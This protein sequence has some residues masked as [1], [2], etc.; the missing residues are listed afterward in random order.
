[1]WRLPEMRRARAPRA[2]LLATL[3]LLAP[4]AAARAA[5]SPS[6]ADA[7]RLRA[8]VTERYQVLP[9]REGVLLVPRQ[10]V[11]G[12]RSI[13][14]ADGEVAIN[15]ETVSPGIL[16]SWLGDE[17]EP[18]LA[19]AEVDPDELG[20]VLGLEPGEEAPAA[21]GGEEPAAT[22]PGEVPAPPATPAP[23]GVPPVPETGAVAPVPPPPPEPDRVHI[24]ERFS[25]GSGVT[26]DADEVASEVVCIGGPVRILGKVD[27]DVVAIGGSVVVEGEVGGDVVGVGGRVFLGAES[28]VRRDVVAVGSGVERESGARV[29]GQV[30]QTTGPWVWPGHVRWHPRGWS[31][32][33]SPVR[34]WYLDNLFFNLVGIVL[35]AILVALVLL[36]ARRTVEAA[37]DR[38]RRDFWT[39]ALTG[40]LTEVLLLPVLFV[41]ALVLVL[42]IVGCLALPLIPVALLVVLVFALVGYAGVAVHLGRLVGERFGWRL[43]RLYGP[44][45]IGLLLIEVWTLIGHVLQVGS[46]LAWVFA[47]MFV[48]I[49]ILVRYVAW[50]TGLGAVVLNFFGSRRR[51][52]GAV[53]P[54]PPPLPPAPTPTPGEPAGGSWSAA[55]EPGAGAAVSEPPADEPVAESGPP[56]DLPRDPLEPGPAVTPTPDESDRVE[57]EPP[58]S[59]RAPE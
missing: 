23:G 31:G 32:D 37:E 48:V 56:A 34:S 16:R 46:G 42:T 30:N 26:V 14:I 59:E 44:A 58:P 20:G 43:G 12:I 21:A 29:G 28:S 3:I 11:P 8:A 54:P 53:P 18:L 57:P 45:L 2:T 33:R 13:E 35:L 7:A 22:A 24:G 36:L 6:A 4:L 10:E 41:V 49:G 51:A 39:A 50:T 25:L 9:A 38:V 15:G 40:L 5:E 19:L 27:G 1:M 52:A 17:A 55:G 47:T